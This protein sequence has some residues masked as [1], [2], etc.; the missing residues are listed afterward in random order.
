MVFFFQWRRMTTLRFHIMPADK[1]VWIFL[2]DWYYYCYADYFSKCSFL[3]VERTGM[4]SEITEDTIFSVSFWILCI[5]HIPKMAIN[6]KSTTAMFVKIKS[7]QQTLLFYLFS[8]TFIIVAFNT[9]LILTSVIAR[10]LPC[11]VL[12]C[13]TSLWPLWRS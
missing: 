12:A 4:C 5:I 10:H 1:V 7:K 9:G 8:R 11:S 13:Y 6:N 3:Y 2:L